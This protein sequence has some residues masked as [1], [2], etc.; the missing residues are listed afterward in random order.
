MV[1][2][3]ACFLGCLG[4]VYVSDSFLEELKAAWSAPNSD[5]KFDLLKLHNHVD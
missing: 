3:P 4:A 1:H 2:L 5:D